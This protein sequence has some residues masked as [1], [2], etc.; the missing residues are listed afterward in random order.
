MSYT[1]IFGGSV[2][3]P[4][5]V[6][7]T[8]FSLTALNSPLALVLPLAFQ[9][10]VSVIAQIVDIAADANGYSLTMPDMTETSVGFSVLF[11]NVSSYTVDVY[12]NDG[13]TLLAS[14]PTAT[15]TYCYLIDNTTSNG[16]FRQVPFGGGVP[17]VINVAAIS[18]SADLVITGSPITNAGTFTFSFGGDIDAII[19]VAG[20]G[21]LTKTGSGT[22]ATDSIVGTLNQITVANGNGVAGNPTISLPSAVSGINSLV[23]SNI[24]IGL[25]GTNQIST[26]DSNPI[27]FGNGASMITEMPLYFYDATNTNYVGL[28]APTSVTT[29]IIYSLPNAPP[30]VSGYTLTST[31]A[32]IMSWAPT[33]PGGVTSLA[34][35]VDQIDVSAATGSVIIS[36]DSAYPGQNSIITLGTVTTGAWNANVITEIYGGT[37]QSSYILGDILYASGVNTLAKLAGN[38]TSAKQY[39]SQTGTGSVSADPVWATI[40]GGDITGAALTEVND[41]NITLTLGGTPATALLRATSITAGWTGQLGVTRG[42]TGLASTTIN[43]LLYSSANNVIAGLATANNATLVTDGS[44]VPSLSAT[45]PIAVIANIPGR[46]INITYLV[47]GTGATYTPTSGTTAIILEAYGSGGGGGGCAGASSSYSAGGGG[48]AGGY[49]LKYITGIDSATYTGTYTIGAFGAGGVGNSAGGNAGNTTY[50]D[51]TVSITCIG[52]TGGGGC[53]SVIAGSLGGLPGVGNGAIGGDIITDGGGGNFGICSDVSGTVA[54][55]GM[56]GTSRIAGGGSPRIV[57]T[58]MVANGINGTLG[59]GG[60]GAASYNT[61]TTG[62][63]GT[64]GVSIIVIYE[65]S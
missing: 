58:S 29:S 9:T 10:S 48:G 60:G 49:A 7:Y 17:A 44:G 14:L 37:N 1:D 21:L 64:G 13:I 5:Y 51:G 46:L 12:L 32:G 2:I 8:S 45:L 56:G 23:A 42:G 52:G 16:Q 38:I 62:T 11:T 61:A 57:S 63:G 22:W 31:T 54:I 59:A 40:S 15:A 33:N 35:T 19:N 36:I 65:F 24:Q 30:A 28:E 6:N 3:S 20:T 25:N 18:T 27:Q 39:L 26:S 41:T 53:G 55:G 34:G 50:T 47:S 43:Q 4:S